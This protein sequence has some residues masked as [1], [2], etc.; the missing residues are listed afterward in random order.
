MYLRTKTWRLSPHSQGMQNRKETGKS[1]RRAYRGGLESVEAA[2]EGAAETRKLASGRCADD[3]DGGAV[4]AD[5]DAHLTDLLSV[6]AQIHKGDG[7][8]YAAERGCAQSNRPHHVS[9]PT[10]CLGYSCPPVLHPLPPANLPTQTSSCNII[11][12]T[13]ASGTPS[14]H[15][16]CMIHARTKANQ[17]R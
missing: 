7:A 15:A 17:W 16:T 2:V 6:S 12:E 8:D 10:D 11:A 14:S 5:E 13:R 4:L 1:E 9:S 3:A